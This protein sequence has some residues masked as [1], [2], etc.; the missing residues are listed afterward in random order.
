M[1]AKK[2]PKPILGRGAFKCPSFENETSA[3]KKSRPSQSESSNLLLDGSKGKAGRQSH[4]EQKG[5]G[6]GT[7]IEFNEEDRQGIRSKLS[8]TF[9]DLE[10]NHRYQNLRFSGRLNFAAGYNLEVSG[11]SKTPRTE[12]LCELY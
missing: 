1:K 2:S 12:S 10:V 7:L 4:T 3:G 11:F 9:A 5:T 6:K 8:S